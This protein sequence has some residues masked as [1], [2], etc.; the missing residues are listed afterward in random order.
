MANGAPDKRGF[1]WPIVSG[2]EVVRWKGRGGAR[3]LYVE[4]E[5]SLLEEE[6][7]IDKIFRTVTFSFLP[8]RRLV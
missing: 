3:C 4:G 6:C 1:L 2:A 8:I 7:L 5:E